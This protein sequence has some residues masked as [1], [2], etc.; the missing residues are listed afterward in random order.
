MTNLSVDG[1]HPSRDNAP[2]TGFSCQICKE[3]N[4]LQARLDKIKNDETR[5]AAYTVNGISLLIEE[6]RRAAAGDEDHTAHS[7]ED[8]LRDEV[9][10]VIASGCDNPAELAA[11]VLKTGDIGFS[12]WFS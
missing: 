9:I 3:L 10:R 6:I 12:R 4:E 7:Y 8:G 11:E 1:K 2:C 5:R